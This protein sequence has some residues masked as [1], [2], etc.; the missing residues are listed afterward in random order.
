[1]LNN[2]FDPL[3]NGTLI[4]STSLSYELISGMLAQH[5]LMV[6]PRECQPLELHLA[7]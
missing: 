2:K 6:R 7:H 4:F 3:P 5:F 1:M